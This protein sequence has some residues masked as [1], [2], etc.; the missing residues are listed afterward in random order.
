[1]KKITF[2][3]RFGKRK[4]LLRTVTPIK[5]E[6]K[7]ETEDGIITTEDEEL[8]FPFYDVKGTFFCQKIEGQWYKIEE[9]IGIDDTDIDVSWMDNPWYYDHGYVV[10]LEGTPDEKNYIFD[11]WCNLYPRPKD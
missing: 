10:V 1:M 7:E 9:D 6:A 11:Y 4:Y 5:V 3:E 2:E 8:L